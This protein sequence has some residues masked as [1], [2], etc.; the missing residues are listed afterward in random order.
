MDYRNINVPVG[1]YLNKPLSDIEDKKIVYFV[2]YQKSDG[3]DG[4]A[5]HITVDKAEHITQKLFDAAVA[6]IKDHPGYQP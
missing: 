2:D 4:V 6:R 1:F 5:S 3:M